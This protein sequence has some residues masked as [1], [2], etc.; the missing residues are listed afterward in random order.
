MRALN[1][2]ISGVQVVDNVIVKGI[3]GDHQVLSFKEELTL[4]MQSGTES[5][6]L[7]MERVRDAIRANMSQCWNDLKQLDRFDAFCDR[8]FV[9]AAQM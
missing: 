1:P 7:C 4:M 2:E 9:A 6:K 8:E 3:F 5:A